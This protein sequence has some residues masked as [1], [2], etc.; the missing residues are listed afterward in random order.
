MHRTL[1]LF[2]CMA[3]QNNNMEHLEKCSIH[4]QHCRKDPHVYNFYKPFCAL[5]QVLWFLRSL[6][7][8]LMLRF[9]ICNCKIPNQWSSK[10]G[11]HSRIVKSRSL[12]Y[13]VRPTYNCKIKVTS[14]CCSQDLYKCIYACFKLA[15][16]IMSST[17]SSY[18]LKQL[19]SLART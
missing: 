10:A 3:S 18:Y 7:F 13:H 14:L 15:E 1:P 19:T 16:L 8:V 12:Y 4:R 17:F 6:Y 9:L 2:L 11:G 5:V